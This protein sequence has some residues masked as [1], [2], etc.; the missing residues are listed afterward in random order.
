MLIGLALTAWS[1]SIGPPAD[2]PPPR[3]RVFEDVLADYDAAARRQAREA[4]P[5]V[6]PEPYELAAVILSLTEVG[7]GLT[8]DTP[9]AAAVREHFGAFR[10]HPAVA[11]ATRGDRPGEA[12]GFFDYIEFRENAYAY[13]FDDEG[14]DR[15]RLYRCQPFSHVWGRQANAFAR[16]LDLIEDFARVSAFRAFYEEHEEHYAELADDLMG[17]ADILAMR[18]W[19]D[20]RFPVRVDAMQVAFSP[21]TDGSHSTQ[22]IE[23]GDFVAV[24]MFVQPVSEIPPDQRFRVERML[25]TELDHNYV[26]PT[27]T[28]AQAAHLDQGAFADPYWVQGGSTDAYGDGFAVFA[29]YATW[30]LYEV[31]ATEQPGTDAAA[32][33]AYLD[34]FMQDDRGFVRYRAFADEMTRLYREEAAKG[35]PVFVPALYPGL[36]AWGDDLAEREASS[37]AETA[38]TRVDQTER[39]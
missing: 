19:L 37:E 10:D 27:I 13:C 38:K 2:G 7:A 3:E 4:P 31:W 20:A 8:A 34:A 15:G 36:I 28:D 32:L 29:E 35:E 12:D 23:D 22:R 18:D 11:A 14:G 16:N 24:A 33:R 6:V 25:F 9:Y 30:A 1:L 21:L 39:D 17:K 26:N 5:Y